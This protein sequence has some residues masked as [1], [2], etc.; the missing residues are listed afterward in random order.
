LREQGL[1]V[2]DCMVIIDR[3][4]GG[5]EKLAEIGVT[6]HVIFRI[7]E[8]LNILVVARKLRPEMA[9]EIRLYLANNR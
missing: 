3:E 4:Q 7:A 6:L 2:N 1:V 5:R 8:L 9:A